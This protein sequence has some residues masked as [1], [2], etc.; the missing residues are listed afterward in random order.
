MV[1]AALLLIVVVASPLLSGK[2]PPPP[3]IASDPL[4]VSGREIYIERCVSCHGDKGRGDGPIAKNLKGPPPRDFTKDQWKYGNEPA[5][6]QKI[7]A[8]G[9]PNSSMPGWLATLGDEKVRAA[10]A[11]VLYL[12]GRG[13]PDEWRPATSPQARKN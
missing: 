12:A 2:S 13:I 6:I 8:Q 7:V 11:Y 5:A 3:E 10:S 1:I 4:L 9:A